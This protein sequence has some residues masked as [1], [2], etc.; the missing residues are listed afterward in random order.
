MNIS[1]YL[2]VGIF[3]I[4]LGVAGTAYIIRSTDGFNDLNTKVYEVVIPDATGLSTNSKVYLAGVPVGKIRSIDLQ[5]GQALLRLAFLRDVEIR[6]DAQIGRKASSLL[7]TSILTLTPGTELSPIVPA[8]GLI[9]AAPAAGSMDT[10]MNSAQALSLQFSE[11]LKD[12]QMRQLELLAVS[13]ET[14]NSIARKLDE[15]SDAELARVS[16]ILESSALITER[17]ERIL[18]EREGD[19]GASAEDIRIALDNLRAMTEEIRRGEGNVG[20]A[21]YDDSLYAG[22]LATVERTEV[23]AEKLQETLEGITRLAGNADRVVN[24]ASEI[25]S[26]AVGLGVQVDAGTRYDV[27]AGAFRGGASLRLE[28]RS[29]DRWYR[30]G[31]AGVPDGISERTVIQT[32]VDGGGATTTDTVKTRYALGF[33]A[34]LA[35]R[36]GPLTLR[37]GLLESS[38]GLGLD[39]Q[40]FDR[41]S[42][43]AEL[44]DFRR[45]SP[46]NLRGSLTLYPFFDPAS[47]KPWHWI[48]L[49]GG[50]NA[51][52]D[53]RRDYFFGAGLR[54]ADEEVRGLVGL[55]PLAGK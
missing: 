50:V 42:F 41:L 48:Y 5:E 2:K 8:G 43:S 53:E 11:M 35:R 45:G 4:G 20:R 15:R 30:V 47:D 7:G 33:D 37:G 32:T 31:V 17:F 14:F 6:S 3:F 36:L 55:V 40:A 19:V 38:A 26:K 49:R 22:L 16:R 54:F 29:K 1:K 51:A 52:L 28:P 23:A 39:Y 27:L 44:F 21:I 34:E 18:R 13:L 46:P 10:I 9:G 24:D 25:V 12:F